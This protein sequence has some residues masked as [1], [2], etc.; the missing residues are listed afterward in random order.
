MPLAITELVLNFGTSTLHT[1]VFSIVH[2]KA[3][4]NQSA[5]AAEVSG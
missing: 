1:F 3:F 5:V 2:K 4:Y